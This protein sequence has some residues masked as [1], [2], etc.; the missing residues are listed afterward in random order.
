MAEETNNQSLLDFAKSHVNPQIIEVDDPSGRKAKVLILP[1][2][3]R[4]QDVKPFLDK[5]LKAPERRE[6]TAQLEDLPSFILHVRRFK[7]ADSAIFAKPNRTQPS[8]T[9]VLDYHRAGG[10][11]AP[12]FG[13]HR[14]TYPF[15][16]SDEW[17]AWT[18]KN[19]QPFTQKEFAEFI[20]DRVSDL[21]DPGGASDT[22]QELARKL[23]GTFATPAKLIDLSREFSVREGAAVK[24]ATN[25]SSGE[26][27]IQ[28]VTT[29]SDDDGKP[30]KVPNLF[31]IHIPVFRSGAPYELAVR[32]RYRVKEGRV[33]WFFELYRSDKAF[34]N[35]FTEACAEAQNATELPLFVG[36]PE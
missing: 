11:G 18:G 3:L 25:L 14:A 20:E 12:R 13:K 2:S 32:L 7:D 22:V 28:Y 36:S 1:R 30:L 27:Q 35:A 5:Y 10:D 8:I 9:A 33:F 4:A 24:Q 31:L 17:R 6:G 16:I 34:D 26:A 23:G 15:P 29:H 19:G 21:A